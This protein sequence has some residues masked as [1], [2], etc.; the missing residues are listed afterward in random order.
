MGIDRLSKILVLS[1]LCIFLS[2]G[3][4][5]AMGQDVIRASGGTDISVDTFFDETFTSISGPTIR[6][7]SVA[8]L[9]EGETIVLTLPSGYIWNDALTGEDITVTVEPVGS[10][11]TDL[12]VEFTGITNSEAT[13]TVTGQSRTAGAGQGPGRLTIGGLELRPN[14]DS[15]PNEGQI[16]N[17]GTTGPSDANY[18]NLSTEEGGISIVRVETAAD[19]SGQ[20]V[21]DQDLRAADDLTVYSVARDQAEN[22]VENIALDDED[23]WSLTNTTGS[24]TTGALDVAANRQSATFNSQQT[25]TTQIRAFFEGVDIVTS[26]TITVTPRTASEMSISTQPSPTATAGEEF[27]TQ[28]ELQLFDQF[29]N[30]VTTDSTTVVTASISEGEGTLSGTL[31][32]TAVEGVISFTDLFSEIANDIVLEFDSDELDSVTSNTITIEPNAGR[33]GLSATA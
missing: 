29:G 27:P 21:Q 32:Q 4:F 1:G 13:F 12:E 22:F 10:Q 2:G 9:Q 30:L 31:I 14:N 18:G 19:G 11:N 23:D 15:V 7:T 25:G 24:I 3:L 8:Q 26:G 28:P 5:S 20:V 6:E 17:S 33:S 16:S